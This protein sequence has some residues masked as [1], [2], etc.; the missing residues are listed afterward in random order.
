[1][2]DQQNEDS[3][4]PKLRMKQETPAASDASK[5]C[6]QCESSLPQDAVLCVQCGYDF[7]SGTTHKT[8]TGLPHTLGVLAAVVISVA[9]AAVAILILINVFKNDDAVAPVATSPVDP[10]P[11]PPAHVPLPPETVLEP[12]AIA[13]PVATPEPPDPVAPVEADVSVE[14]P[15]E[16]AD[17]AEPVDDHSDEEMD[18]VDTQQ[19]EADLRR[20]L[21]DSLNQRVPAHQI[22]DEVALRRMNGFVHRGELVAIRDGMALVVDGEIRERVPLN[23]LDRDSRLLVDEAFRER[24][25]ESRLQGMLKKRQ[26]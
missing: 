21:R 15:D 14:T 6:P 18:T 19:E 23:E 4:T 24:L 8:A 9:V 11:P 25:V 1:M 13:E 2:D 5:S 3:E 10:P 7:R 20:A 16:A 22:G 17:A 12:T 26:E